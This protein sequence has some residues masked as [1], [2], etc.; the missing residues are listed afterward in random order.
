MVR[1]FTVQ[2]SSCSPHL[3]LACHRDGQSSNCLMSIKGL[4]CFPLVV[5]GSCREVSGFVEESLVTGFPAGCLFLLTKEEKQAFQN[6]PLTHECNWASFTVSTADFVAQDSF[7]ATRRVLLLVLPYSSACAQ[8]INSVH[9]W[10]ILLILVFAG[11]GNQIMGLGGPQ[12]GGMVQPPSIPAS[13][14]KLIFILFH[15][16]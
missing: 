3:R 12:G 13:S 2:T 10:V 8:A 16:I 4:K 7:L 11:T 1:G 15:V 5:T 9:C 6:I 14:C